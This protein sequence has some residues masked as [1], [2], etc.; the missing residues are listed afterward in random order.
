MKNLMY[1]DTQGQFEPVQNAA[2]VGFVAL[3][4]RSGTPYV[5]MLDAEKGK[6]ALSAVLGVP[7]F[8][9]D[10]QVVDAQSRHFIGKLG[11]LIREYDNLEYQMLESIDEVK[12]LKPGD[13]V[14]VTNHQIKPPAHHNKKLGTW[15]AKNF[16][17]RFISMESQQDDGR[18]L[19]DCFGGDIM[20]CVHTFRP[21]TFA[22][23][24]NI[25]P[26][27]ELTQYLS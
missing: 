22:K 7:G 10:T 2:H 1:F 24:L 8:S 15:R 27:A 5:F 6:A 17:A 25:T 14:Y 16:I 4:E 11:E 3:S 18:F 9:I 21:E 19:L 12:A 23:V 13:F 20:H 26:Q